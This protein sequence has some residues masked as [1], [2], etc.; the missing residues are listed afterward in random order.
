MII[1]EETSPYRRPKENSPGPGEHDG[2]L[3]SIGESIK[4]NIGMG[5]NMFLSQIKIQLQD[6]T[7]QDTLRQKQNLKEVTS[8]LKS[9]S[10]DFGLMKRMVVQVSK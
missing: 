5:S 8:N 2:H 10:Q 1:R 6:S 9:L 4:T 7:N 3:T